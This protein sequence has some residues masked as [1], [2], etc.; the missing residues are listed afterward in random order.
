MGAALQ[1]CQR[2]LAKCQTYRDTPQGGDLLRVQSSAPF[3]WGRPPFAPDK[4]AVLHKLQDVTWTSFCDEVEGSRRRMVYE[5]WTSVLMLAVLCVVALKRFW[6]FKPEAR[7]T[8]LLVDLGLW[9]L[10]LCT[11]YWITRTNARLDEKIR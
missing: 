7:W 9:L 8:L 11:A 3:C 6:P 4:P 5:D 2:C 1:G 10:V